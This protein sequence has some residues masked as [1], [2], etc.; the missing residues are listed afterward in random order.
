MAVG[1]IGV[2]PGVKHV[3]GLLL[4]DPLVG[5]PSFL[6]GSIGAASSSGFNS[7]LPVY[8]STIEGPTTNGN[9]TRFTAG[10]N[11]SESQNIA[12]AGSGN[13]VGMLMIAA[14]NYAYNPALLS[15]GNRQLIRGTGGNLV[16]A[17]PIYSEGAATS[18]D[19]ER[20]GQ[21]VRAFLYAEDEDDALQAVRLRA[22]AAGDLKVSS[23]LPGTITT[24]T[25]VALA[26]ATTT[27]I[28]AANTA[29]SVAIV[30]N[31]SGVDAIRVGDTN[32]D[33][34]RGILLNPLES[35][36]LETTAEIFA[37]SSAGST[38][39]FTEIET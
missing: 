9:V 13:G 7:G 10:V 20:A 17:N 25:G 1:L 22:T 21:D 24:A 3:V 16:T 38:V 29:R 39:D 34:A 27:S 35:V 26:A 37:F 19:G 33:G 6:P 8:P 30:Q 14:A 2:P 23:A 31:P 5:D 4:N 12:F 28:I 32:I 18:D 11:N 36:T 15:F